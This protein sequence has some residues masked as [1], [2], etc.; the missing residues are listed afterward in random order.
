MSRET[1]VNQ[2]FVPVS[3]GRGRPSNQDRTI[4]PES[5]MAVELG[6][7]RGALRNARRYGRLK[8]VTIGRKVYLTKRWIQEWVEY[9]AKCRQRLRQQNV[10]E[11]FRRLREMNK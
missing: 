3:L 1:Q 4:Q 2:P 6:I 10:A 11:H 7:P 9:D 5:A 8:Y